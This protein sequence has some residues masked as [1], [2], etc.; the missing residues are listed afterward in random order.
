MEFLCIDFLNSDWRDW[1]GS[2]RRENRLDNPVWM[3]EFLTHWGGDSVPEPDAAT[4]LGLVELRERMRAMVE[5][6]VEGRPLGEGDIELLNQAMQQVPAHSQLVQTDAAEYRL[7]QVTPAHGWPWMIGQIALS[8][9]KLITEEDRRRI[10]ICD[11][12][13]CRWVFFDESRNRAKRWC[14]D[15]CCGNLLKVRRFRERQKAKEQTD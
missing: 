11:N 13:D 10:K 1:R 2:G 7:E 12:D 6:L 4:R 8:F 5:A 15:K 9:A 3:K 14:D